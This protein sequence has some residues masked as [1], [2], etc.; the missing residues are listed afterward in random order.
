MAQEPSAGP[1]RLPPV[2]SLSTLR[3]Q[4]WKGPDLVLQPTGAASIGATPGRPF[5][6]RVLDCRGV[7]VHGLHLKDAACWMQNYLNCEDLLIERLTA[8]NQANFNNDGLDIDGCRHVIVRDC[9]IT[10]M[11]P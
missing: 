11:P 4:P 8:D 3:L 10:P 7:H 6:I 5:L 9:F 2:S 1:S